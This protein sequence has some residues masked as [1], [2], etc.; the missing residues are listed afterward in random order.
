MSAT[1]K[2]VNEL[3]EKL[4][5]IVREAMPKKGQTIWFESVRPKARGTTVVPYDRIF[6]PFAGPAGEFVD[7]AY[8]TG[9]EPAKGPGG[10]PKDL[11]GRIQFTRADFGRMGL[12]SESKSDQL[13]FQYMFLTNQNVSNRDKPWYVEGKPSVFKQDEPRRRAADA[14]EFDRKVRQ[15]MDAID[16]MEKAQLLEIASGLDMDWVNEHT[17]ESEIISLLYDIAKKNPARVLGLDKD[18]TLKMKAD[19]KLAEKLGIIKRNDQLQMWVWPESGEKICIY[20][21]DKDTATSMVAYFMGTGSK[22]YQY[23]RN[24]ID[25]EIESKK[26]SKAA[27]AK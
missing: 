12:R 14:I 25:A 27:K 3:S 15:A 13:L 8:I 2:K 5:E 18:V 9:T 23:I 17:D 16:R 11:I 1:T 4:L 19:V 24:M 22:T 26:Q 10:T 7:I 21:P 6:D 20:Q